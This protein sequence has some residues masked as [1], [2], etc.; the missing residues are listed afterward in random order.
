MIHDLDRETEELESSLREVNSRLKAASLGKEQKKITDRLARLRNELFVSEQQLQKSEE[1]GELIKKDS[2]SRKLVPCSGKSNSMSSA[3]DRNS[4]SKDVRFKHSDG[5]TLS[6]FRAMPGL[7]SD[8]DKL[9]RNQ[10]LHSLRVNQKMKV[11]MT[12]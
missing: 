2:K 12:Q 5:V 6:D 4:D 8:V 7:N 1:E 9:D 11:A 3:K 10:S